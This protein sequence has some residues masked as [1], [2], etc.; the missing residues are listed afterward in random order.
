MIVRIPELLR[1]ISTRLS[2]KH[3]EHPPNFLISVVAI[4]QR[5]IFLNA[6]TDTVSFGTAACS[7]DEVNIMMDMLKDSSTL[8]VGGS[9]WRVHECNFNNR[10]LQC[11]SQ[12]GL[13]DEVFL[14]LAVRQDTWEVFGSFGTEPRSHQVNIKK[15][16]VL[17]RTH[18]LANS[19]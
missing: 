15:A 10:R 12:V 17:L 9:G 1:N 2:Y 5:D 18:V 7:Q 19:A 11:K 14:K 16:Q 13:Y 8:G 6:P 4:Q 3:R